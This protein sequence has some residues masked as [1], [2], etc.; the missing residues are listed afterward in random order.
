MPFVGRKGRERS[1]SEESPITQAV[2][3]S[4]ATQGDELRVGAM[5]AALKSFGSLYKAAGEGSHKGCMVGVVCA[6][7]RRGILY[8]T[9]QTLCRGY[10]K[11]PCSNVHS[12]AG[13]VGTV[14]MRFVACSTSI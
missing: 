12:E 3:Q 4:R 9:P 10:A 8:T 11:V 2:S 14:E 6:E 13:P 5:D 1:S 7:V